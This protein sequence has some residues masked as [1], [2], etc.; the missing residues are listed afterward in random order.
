MYRVRIPLL[1]KDIGSFTKNETERGKREREREKV[2]KK[3]RER[4]REKVRKKE[5][6]KMFFKA[7][8]KNSK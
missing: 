8:N 5:R 1:Q 4:E 7:P 2:R 6:D 3:E